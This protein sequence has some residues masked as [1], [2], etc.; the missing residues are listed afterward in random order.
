M[1]FGITEE[2]AAR[3]AY[4]F[5]RGIDIEEVGF[6]VHPTIKQAGCSPDGYVGADGLLEIKCPEANAMWE[7]LVKSPVKKEYRE[8]TMWQLACT[9]RA[10][11]DLVFYSEGC[12][13]DITRID[14]DPDLIRELEVAVLQFL[15]EVESDYQMLLDA[16]RR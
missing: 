11:C 13:L 16:Q 1:A 14:R 5:E 15:R 3:N 7:A 12:P 9:G 8:Q 10:W 2:A 4:A 6:I